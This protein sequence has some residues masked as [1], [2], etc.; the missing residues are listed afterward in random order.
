VTGTDQRLAALEQQVAKMC[1]EMAA[2]R[3]SVD[4]HMWAD[5]VTAMLDALGMTG[6]PPI[7]IRAAARRPRPRHLRRV[8]GE[9]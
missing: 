1:G 5:R 4:A 2:L 3:L 9:S 7:R 8:G 6:P